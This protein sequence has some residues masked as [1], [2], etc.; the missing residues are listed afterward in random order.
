MSGSAHRFVGIA[1]KE[2]VHIRR[3]PQTL[4]LTFVMPLLMMLLYGYAIRLDLRAVPFVVRDLDHS[5]ASREIVAALAANPAFTFRGF[6]DR[7][8][9]L[10]RDLVSGRAKVAL[11]IPVG[12]GRG[13]EPPQVLIDG[14]EP[15]SGTLAMAYVRAILGSHAP[16]G[17]PGIQ[18]PTGQPVLKP[19]AAPPIEFRP[20]ILFNPDLR[21]ANFI[22]PGLVAILMMMVCA[23]LTSITIARERERGS[24]E[25]L[26]VSPVNR[27]E[28]ILGKVLPYILV[29][30]F[31][32]V[33]VILF[34][35]IV[36]GV[37]IRGSYALLA[38]TT[39]L[40][41]FTA[42]GIGV[43]ISS[44][45]R[46]QQSAMMGALLATIMPSV[47]LSGFVFP[48]RS[49]P[50]LLQVLCWFIPARHFLTIIRGIVLRGA[51]FLDLW[52]SI[53]YLLILGF[54][55]VVV[56]TLRFRTRLT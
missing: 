28:I 25:Q 44:L 27:L 49:M 45:V 50:P 15:N 12:Y 13:D 17:Q 24:F 9:E 43:F 21:S 20:R 11:T 16:G 8:T 2:F 7:D 4:T 40:Y 22:V 31:I 32:A 34:G 47:M 23:L 55:F 38:A 19:P 14:S 1:R 39:L 41:G 6:R 54:F 36:F 37:P 51:V 18:P 48:I 29:A 26:F 5:P 33:A 46:T 53:L 42:L 30:F 52:P 56:S 10:E 3:D 35:R